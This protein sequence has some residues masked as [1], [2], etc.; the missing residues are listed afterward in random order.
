MIDSLNV[1]N[2]VKALIG[3]GYVDPSKV[4]E[5][6]VPLIQ[7]YNLPFSSAYRDSGGILTDMSDPQSPVNQYSQLN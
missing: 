4:L 7:R 6:F 2:S 3:T 5:E 1:I